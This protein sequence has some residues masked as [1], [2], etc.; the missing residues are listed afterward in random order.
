MLW[1]MMWKERINVCFSPDGEWLLLTSTSGG[2][3]VEPVAVPNQFQPYGDLYAVR[4]DE[5]ALKRLT[6][7][8][9]ENAMPAWHPKV[10]A[11]LGYWARGLMLAISSRVN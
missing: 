10:R 5:S 1:V 2:L 11:R 9:Y 7:N 4:L 8:G 3:T 6:W